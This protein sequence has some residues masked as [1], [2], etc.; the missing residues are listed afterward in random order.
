MGSQ[1]SSIVK[2]F[3]DEVK[4]YIP[5]LYGGID[6]LR[7]A[8]DSPDVT[9]EL[10]RLVHIVH[11][12]ASLVG[13]NGLS[14]TAAQMEDTLEEVM[15]G[16]LPVGAG[17]LDAMGATVGN[18]EAYTTGEV[19]CRADEESI[20][21]DTVRVFRR[22][23]GLPEAGDEK[24][25]HGI[26]EEMGFA[27]EGGGCEA[28]GLF[29]PALSGDGMGRPQAVDPLE[30]D[31]GM[32][33]VGEDDLAVPAPFSFG[34][35]EPCVS[36]DPEDSTEKPTH[37]ED[38]HPAFMTPEIIA[39]F[40]EEV[41]EHFEAINRN[42][43]ALEKDVI[44][45]VPLGEGEKEKVRQVRRAV[46]TIKGASSLVGVAGLPG[47]AHSV[48]DLLDW[49]FDEA[50]E[51]GPDVVSALLK[52]TDIM[53]AFI[54]DPSRVRQDDMAVL[55]Q[56]FRR[57]S[58]VPLTPGAH[59]VPLGSLAGV[60]EETSGI[61]DS[62]NVE[63]DG[64]SDAEASQPLV[65]GT[66][67]VG[68]EK[69]DELVNLASEQIIALSA[70]DQKMDAFLSTVGE[71]DLS[72]ERLRETSRNLE[73][74]YE[75]K[76]IQKPGSRDAG[77]GGE[78]GDSF[79]DF[80]SLE[81]DRYSEFN[82][83]IRD[84]A[85]SVVD[86]GEIYSGMQNFHSDFEGYIT[87]QRVLLSELQG[88]LMH[89]RMAPMSVITT[90]MRRAVRDVADRLGKKVRLTI[91]G[92][93][94]ELD[95]VIWEKLSDPLLHILRNA[96]DHGIEP[97]RVRKEAGKPETGIIAVSASR[98]G[99]QVVIRIRDD[100]AGLNLEA[101]RRRAEGL[102][103]DAA[104][105]MGGDELVGLLFTP[106]FTTRED[107]TEISGRGVGMDVVKTNIEE[108]K[109]SVRISHPEAG[110]GTVLT[111]RIPLTLAVIRAILCTAG[112]QTFAVPLNDI[113][114]IL[115]VYPENMI[116]EPMESVR[117]GEDVFPLYHLSRALG[118]PD[119]VS[120]LSG[121]GDRP[122]VLKIESSDRTGAF[123]V[124]SLLGQQ[125]IVIK[126]LGSH[127]QYVKGISGATVMGD[128]SI[129]PI[130]D[131]S[132]LFSE[133]TGSVAGVHPGETHQA[134]PSGAFVHASPLK[135][136]IVDDSVSVRQVVARLMEGQGWQVTTAKDG[137][138]ALER[139]PIAAPDL[140]VLDVEMPRMNGYEFLAARRSNVAHRNIPVVMLTSR[141]TAK[142]R[143]KA[144]A[145]G[146][147]GFVVKPFNDNEFLTLI[148][149]LT[150]N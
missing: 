131:V 59:E 44:R 82:L 55:R 45:V 43:E 105:A 142:Y 36:P 32:L 85:E 27:D 6:T 148:H 40:Y 65:A 115:R 79:S 8:P 113:S 77:P 109:G 119:A 97:P 41:E 17:L 107:V 37:E 114:D 20:I 134:V 16:T 46:H 1:D 124:D 127:L 78:G 117:V 64:A 61:F 57:I 103:G 54:S 146:A 143:E 95:R 30:A 58:G 104:A 76:A 26:L 11:G 112:G 130:V 81:L 118:M 31:G 2:G 94:I 140:I 74:G 38:S 96:A 93:G 108:L 7:R 102:F 141:S 121:V 22:V 75:V 101:I 42:L 69:L 19:P 28:D 18:F 25:L 70:F 10:Y 21:I 137:I 128:G 53:E 83:M 106:G 100:G 111:V 39:V 5:S 68:M 52:S 91:R 98:E 14:H 88:K 150:V 92:E 56:E 23:R 33:F 149:S 125:E 73:V 126:S 90:R 116:Y 133:E 62:A 34:Q 72:R 122:I 48:E 71:L 139:L 15:D 144:R 24:V 110:H 4:T 80:D 3:I 123:A 51:V 89:I 50:Q 99:N 29:Q 145:L 66:F 13:L 120:G 86:I 135:I 132:E 87:R 63:E 67:R 60:G 35:P 12:A 49:L 47:W 129:V 136:M 9:Q 147:D 138:E 84:L